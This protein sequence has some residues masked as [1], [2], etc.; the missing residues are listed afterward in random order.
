MP[1]VAM[2][3]LIALAIGLPGLLRPIERSDDAVTPAAALA[4]AAAVKLQGPVFNSEGFGGYL[5]FREIPAFIDGRAELY[6]NAFLTRYLAAESGDEGALAAL[7]D[8]YGITWTL[9]M[10]RQGAVRCLD[11]LPGWRRIYSDDRAVI[12]IR[13]G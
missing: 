12:H 13:E 3:L 4:A 1:A 7:L 2:A 10:P 9:L 8:R 5:I 11:K 6:G